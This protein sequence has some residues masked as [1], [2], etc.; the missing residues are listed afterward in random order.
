MSAE[1][2]PKRGRG[3]PPVDAV[4]GPQ[5]AT[6]RSRALRE[7]RAQERRQEAEKRE[8]AASTEAEQ[9]KALAFLAWRL[10][11]L[12]RSLACSSELPN[13]AVL[14]GWR[15]VRA[16]V[17]GRGDYLRSLIAANLNPDDLASWDEGMRMLEEA[18]AKAEKGRAEDYEQWNAA[19][20]K[21]RAS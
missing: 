18:A 9:R 20:R 14:N 19:G 10:T 12:V 5:T 6:E 16:D 17:G 2:P 8:Q 15:V 3:R 7:R 21:R 4:R 1:A 11:V 13:A